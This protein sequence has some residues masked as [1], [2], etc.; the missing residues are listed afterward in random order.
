MSE[1]QPQIRVIKTRG[2]GREALVEIDG[3][4]IVVTDAFSPPGDATARDMPLS[5]AR[6]F[7]TVDEGRRAIRD[8]IR[9]NPDR[10]TRIVQR[11]V[12]LWLAHGRIEA[13]RPFEMNCGSVRVTIW[14]LNDDDPSWLHHFMTAP[15]NR[16]ELT[17]RLGA[18]DEQGNL[19]LPEL[20]PLGADVEL[21]TTVLRD[22]AAERNADRPSA[23][24]S[25]DDDGF[26]AQK[27]YTMGQLLMLMTAATVV[28]GVMRLLEPSFGTSLVGLV[29]LVT[30][31]FATDRRSAP[32]IVRLAWWMLLAI[33]VISA[34]VT[35]RGM[36]G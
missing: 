32:A 10:I 35:V 5:G 19:L 29:L 18:E 1:S 36:L 25:P 4:Q 33:Y 17:G 26:D 23:P 16:L 14:N 12:G 22:R 13:T 21:E 24:A 9:V 28:F 7:G 30:M 31:F 8:V 20:P 15:L 27:H 2:R 11:G 34:V 3:R 6:L